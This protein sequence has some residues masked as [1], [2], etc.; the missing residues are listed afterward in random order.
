MTDL[1][2]KLKSKEEGQGLTLLRGSGGTG[3]GYFLELEKYLR[4]S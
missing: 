3:T 1:L 2:S 4:N